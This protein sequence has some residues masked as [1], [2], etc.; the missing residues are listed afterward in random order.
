MK[1]SKEEHDYASDS[2]KYNAEDQ[3]SQELGDL[4]RHA[5]TQTT[6]VHNEL[7]PSPLAHCTPAQTRINT[8]EVLSSIWE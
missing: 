2:R 4:R 3:Q 7:K 5:A 6:L 1:D 8:G